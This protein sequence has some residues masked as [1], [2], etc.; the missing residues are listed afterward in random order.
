[1][2]SFLL[3]VSLIIAIGCVSAIAGCSILG[4][5]GDFEVTITNLEI[6]ITLH[7]PEVSPGVPARM[8]VTAR[9][10]ASSRIVW[11][12]GSG[13]CQLIAAA[14]V[15]GTWV[16]IGS[17][18]GCTKDLRQWGLDPGE[19]RTEVFTWDGRVVR[20]G[21]SEQL[22]PGTYPVRGEVDD[23]GTSASALITIR[24]AP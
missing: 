16:P 21:Q 5:G 23:K 6:T 18:G 2:R 17:Q 20:G 1:M 12:Q 22:P 14:Q 3:L 15:N 8:S 10:T 9:N 13:S 24:A 7:I 11:G 19:F 4:L